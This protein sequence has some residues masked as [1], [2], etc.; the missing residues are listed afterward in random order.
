[1]AGRKAAVLMATLAVIAGL[2][3]PIAGARQTCREPSFKGGCATEGTVSFKAGQS[4]TP[5][6]RGQSGQSI[7]P[8]MMATGG[9]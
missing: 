1:M 2:S 4:T 9:L 7:F 6:P 5:P 3:A 8:W